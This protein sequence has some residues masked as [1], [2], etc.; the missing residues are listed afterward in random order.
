MDLRDCIS[1]DKSEVASCLEGFFVCA[2][3]NLARRIAESDFGLAGCGSQRGTK[4]GLEVLVSARP[5]MSTW[6]A[7]RQDKNIDSLHQYWSIWVLLHFEKISLYYLDVFVILRHHS[8]SRG[9]CLLDVFGRCDLVSV[10]WV[11]GVV[12]FS[13]MPWLC[14]DCRA[15]VLLRSIWYAVRVGCAC[16]VA[17]YVLI[18]CRRLLGDHMV[19]AP[20]GSLWLLYWVSRRA[21]FAI[22]PL[23]CEAFLLKI[24][25][26]LV[27]DS[28]WE[29]RRLLGVFR[30]VALLVVVVIVVLSSL[31]L[32]L[33]SSLWHR[34]MSVVYVASVRSFGDRV[35]F[36]CGEL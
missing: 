21:L 29:K 14:A 26:R 31:V 27:W 19:P 30:L 5:A 13:V 35:F 18:R 17:F 20:S 24:A 25:A 4:C 36:F 1:G 3:V 33:S 15:L 32:V 34:C 6:Y 28:F 11:V 16:A 2:G 10:V 8:V 12:S 22:A 9:F 23:F 7:L